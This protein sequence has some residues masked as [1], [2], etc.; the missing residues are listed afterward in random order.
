[1][2]IICLVGLTAVSLHLRAQ[3]VQVKIGEHATI[4]LERALFKAAGNVLKFDKEKSLH[5]IN[6][7]PAF[8]TDVEL[9]RYTLTKAILLLNGRY[10]QLKVS[11]MYNPWVG[12]G[13]AYYPRKEAFRLVK[14][15]RVYKLKGMFSDGAGGYVAAW[16]I[17]DKVATRTVLTTDDTLF[18]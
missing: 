2:K 12:D 17:T 15:G 14:A 1:M 6:G 7:Q 16:Q 5:S 9:P 4:V 10:Y 8:G 3:Q 13:A 11:G 18:F